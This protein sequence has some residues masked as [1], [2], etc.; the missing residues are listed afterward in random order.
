MRK[1]VDLGVNPFLNAFKLPVTKINIKGDFTVVKD[2]EGEYLLPK[3]TYVESRVYCRVYT[4]AEARNILM[5]LSSSANKLYLWVLYKSDKNEDYVYL[6]KKLFM[7]TSGMSLNTFKKAV[8]EI[9]KAGIITPSI[10]K[11][12]YWVNPD[13]FFKGNP[14]NKFEDNV[15][16]KYNLTE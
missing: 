7:E 1:H 13:W 2:D 14:I 15:I 9:C 11:E 6:N 16:I 10:A 3:T 5:S 4:N 8:D 12:Y